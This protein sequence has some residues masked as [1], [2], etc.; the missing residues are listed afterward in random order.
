MTESSVWSRF[1][2]SEMLCL[3]CP[4]INWNA[5]QIRPVRIEQ[6]EHRSSP[7]SRARIN[8]PI[9]GAQLHDVKGTHRH[10]AGRVW[11]RSV[12]EGIL[13]PSCANARGFVCDKR[14]LRR[15]ESWQMEH[16]PRLCRPPRAANQS[17]NPR[18][19]ANTGRVGLHARL[20]ME[21][22]NRYQQAR[23]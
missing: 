22:S 23:N 16:G 19:D 14:H 5:A 7:G 17:L 13:R 15:G 4:E 11:V 10:Y 18:Y 6:T 8:Q 21:L 9:V 3:G 20:G 1:E 12:D 2:T